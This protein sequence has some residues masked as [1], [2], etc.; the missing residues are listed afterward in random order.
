[1]GCGCKKNKTKIKP[2]VNNWKS[3]G[4]SKTSVTTRTSRT[5]S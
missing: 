1:M 3:V 4:K 5:K 2:K